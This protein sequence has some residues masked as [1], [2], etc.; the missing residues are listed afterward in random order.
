MGEYNVATG[1]NFQVEI[2][3][4]SF[5]NFISVSGLGVQA[6][7]SD[8][9]GGMDVIGRKVAGKVNYGPV[10]LVR[11]WDPTDRQLQ[12]WWKKVEAPGEEPE[13]KNI[14]IVIKDKT[15]S[16]EVIRRNL[17]LCLPSG[18]EISDLNSNQSSILTETI[19]VVYDSAEWAN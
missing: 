14:S 7:V 15:N 9:I 3:S 5:G 1:Q 13:T 18:Y 19:T 11:N 16:V 4:I 8:D 2:D 12:D 6:D 10:T 17:M